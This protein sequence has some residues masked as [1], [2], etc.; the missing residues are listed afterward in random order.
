MSQKNYHKNEFSYAIFDPT[1]FVKPDGKTKD[2]ISSK[3][4][5]RP[6]NFD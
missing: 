5:S 6:K 1:Q 2:I 3:L 4:R